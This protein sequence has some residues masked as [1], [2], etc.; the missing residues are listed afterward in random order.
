[1]GKHASQ[2]LEEQVRRSGQSILEEQQRVSAE[3]RRSQELA[4]E[5]AQLRVT[6]A[7]LRARL[8]AET[9][10]ATEAED[11]AAEAVRAATPPADPLGK[12]KRCDEMQEAA[13]HRI[14]AVEQVAP[15]T[16]DR[17]LARF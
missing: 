17:R 11:R 2:I 15:P 16:H 9:I 4:E 1:V 7:Q 10:R 14:R 13:E 5:T 8:E 12:C 3:R 6:S